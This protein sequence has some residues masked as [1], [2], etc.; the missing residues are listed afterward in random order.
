MNKSQLRQKS[1]DLNFKITEKIQS[2][3]LDYSTINRD[4]NTQVF[5]SHKDG[6]REGATV[7]QLRLLIKV[8]EYMLNKIKWK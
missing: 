1:K 7:K 8:E 6:I 5:G 4:I 3:G 2:H